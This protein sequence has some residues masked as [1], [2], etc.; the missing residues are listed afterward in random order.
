MTCQ[1]R[2]PCPARLTEGVIAAAIIMLSGFDGASA[3]VPPISLAT[4][5]GAG[6]ASFGGLAY[7]FGGS[8]G[9]GNDAVVAS[10]ISFQPKTK[11][12]VHQASLHQPLRDIAAVTVDES[13]F[14]FG[15]LSRASC[16]AACEP[17][18]V[19]TISRFYPINRTLVNVSE[20]PEG[21]F[22]MAAVRLDHSILLIG[23]SDGR[24]VMS[25]VWRFSLQSNNVTP[26]AMLPEP[27]FRATAVSTP[28]ATIIGGGLTCLHLDCPQHR[29]VE[30]LSNGR[31]NI[32]EIPLPG[33]ATAIVSNG[34]TIFAMGQFLDDTGTNRI[35]RVDLSNG[36]I[37]K[38]RSEVPSGCVPRSVTWT[39][40]L[41]VV[42]GGC[43]PANPPVHPLAFHLPPQA[44]VA[45][46]RHSVAGLE[47]NSDATASFDPDGALS[48]FQW[49]WGDGTMT[50]IGPRASHRYGGPGQFTVILTVWDDEGLSS[51][52]RSTVSVSTGSERTP[53]VSAV[54]TTVLSI[55]VAV[56]LPSA[57]AQ[58]RRKH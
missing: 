35:L 2:S 1:P 52:S 17:R 28:T 20:L 3:Q 51:T 5:E 9:T 57:Y 58:Q 47:V 4:L 26:F 37:S 16:D 19:K 22:G 18:A 25:T 24:E 43:D 44:P 27:L 53:S 14:L 50:T 48:R 46:A 8:S 33:T 31:A 23:G 12:S 21:R 32:V 29:L 56:A 42:I 13:I 10:I 39:G 38:E 11:F 41:A 54:L 30:L 36:H 15:G 40:D 7:S 6:T 55:G 49:E 45:S 34:T